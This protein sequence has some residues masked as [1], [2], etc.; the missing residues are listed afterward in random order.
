VALALAIRRKRFLRLSSGD[1]IL[2]SRSQQTESQQPVLQSKE[3]VYYA[4]SHMKHG[5]E[6][7]GIGSQR[8][9]GLI[10]SEK[11]KNLSWAMERGGGRAKFRGSRLQAADRR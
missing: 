6:P 9:D 11:S 4:L 7:P 8:P 5:H 2:R 10:E 1:H 3:R